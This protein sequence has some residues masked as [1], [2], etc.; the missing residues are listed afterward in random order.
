MLA[1]P[2]RRP[3][4]STAFMVCSVTPSHR[5]VCSVDAS[6]LCTYRAGASAFAN[7]RMGSGITVDQA[8]AANEEE[9][10]QRHT[11]T[12]SNDSSAAKAAPGSPASQLRVS[13]ELYWPARQPTIGTA[14][15]P[16]SSP[17]VPV[18]L[19]TLADQMSTQPP[20]W[21]QAP[22]SGPARSSAAQDVSAFERVLHEATAGLRTAASLASARCVKGVIQHC[23]PYASFA[24]C[25][26]CIQCEQFTM[27]MTGLEIRLAC[28]DMLPTPQPLE[29]HP[30]PE[31]SPQLGEQVM[32]DLSPHVQAPASRATTFVERMSQQPVVP[33]ATK[34]GLYTDSGGASTGS[35]TTPHALPQRPQ[36]EQQASEAVLMRVS[37][38]AEMGVDG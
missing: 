31:P 16:R 12:P 19:Q 25:T 21:L 29:W 24:G 35:D 30:S 28:R 4:C 1:Q 7:M 9:K 8:T 18:S 22:S 27:Q 38:H 6:A 11:R 13:R 5:T 34:G 17:V 15:R 3:N 2:G 20:P 23:P 10:P 14:G 33:N 36:H 37:K 32:M 26:A